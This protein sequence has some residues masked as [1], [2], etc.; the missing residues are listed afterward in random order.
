MLKTPRGLTSSARREDREPWSL[1]VFRIGGRLMAMKAQEVGGVWP[2]PGSVPV[3][4]TTPW[5]CGIVRR[6]E[7]ILPIFDLAG[8]LHVTVKG[9]QPLC[10]IVRHRDGPVAICIDDDIPNLHTVEHAAIN[11]ARM[12]SGLLGTTQFASETV[13][14]YALANLIRSRA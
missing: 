8:S 3:P 13:P 14:I 12:E 9:A 11:S 10:L 4:S 6:D 2:W 5:V 7:D 1:V